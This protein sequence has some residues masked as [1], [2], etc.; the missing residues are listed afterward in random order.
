M[1]DTAGS[2]IDVEAF[3]LL[4]RKAVQ[5]AIRIHQAARSPI[6]IGKEGRPVWVD[7]ENMQELSPEV[8][9]EWRQGKRRAW[10]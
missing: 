10:E 3:L 1:S 4:A 6:V 5:R 8:L 7:P 9:E 2:S